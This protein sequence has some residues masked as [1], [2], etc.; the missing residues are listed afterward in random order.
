IR[1]AAAVEDERQEGVIEVILEVMA[2]NSLRLRG[3]H[4]LL[5]HQIGAANP[6][7]ESLAVKVVKVPPSFYY[8][9][10]LKVSK[11]LS[12]GKKK[13]DRENFYAW[14]W[15][16]L[17]S[18]GLLGIHEGTVLSEEAEKSG[19][20]RDSWTVDSAEAPRERDWV[21]DESLSSAEL[22]FASEKGA[23]KTLDVLKNVKGLI[24]VAG[25]VEV[26][27]QDWDADWK[28]SFRGARV[29]PFWVVRPPWVSIDE[30]SL[31]SGEKLIRINPG[32][33]FGTGTHETTQL[34]LK[35]IGQ[36]ALRL[37]G[38]L[39]DVRVLDFGSGSG[40]LSIAA[41]LLGAKVDAV[42]IDSLAIAN[43]EENASLNS[44]SENVFFTKH[45]SI[46]EPIN[47]IVV[48]NIL[49]P[50]L[51]DNAAL[52]VSSLS[53]Q[54]LLILSGLTQSDIDEVIREY[55]KLLGELEPEIHLLGE[56]RAL[57]WH[58]L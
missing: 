8:L 15:A 58:K 9:V 26:A 41:A 20:S 1:A 22:Y 18:E 17:N 43:A 45:L 5:K 38:T 21:E 6:V 33:G 39:E 12:V 49:R 29:E 34:C 36:E 50:V 46:A 3:L 14:L 47:E 16:S 56:W 10:S 51:I 23:V 48:A 19:I 54:G 42:E 31:E 37:G 11:Q 57:T 24:L 32:A 2:A 44:V 4:R 35:E 53:S 25:P 40:I 7:V 52:L 13:L 30:E 27:N 55:S 28:A